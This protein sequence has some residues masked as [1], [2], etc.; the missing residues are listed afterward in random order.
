VVPVRVREQD[1]AQRR[2][3]VAS[4]LQSIGRALHGLV[5][6]DRAEERGHVR[7]LRV[8]LPTKAGI[9]QQVAARVSDQHRGRREVAW[10]EEGPATIREGRRAMDD[11]GGQTKHGHARGRAT[12]RKGEREW[13]WPRERRGETGR[14]GQAQS[15]QRQHRQQRPGPG[16]RG[17]VCAM[18]R[19]R[20]PAQPYLRVEV[21]AAARERRD[22]TK[23]G[24]PPWMD[25]SD[26]W[27]SRRSNS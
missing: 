11:A 19:M 5:A 2:T 1:T 25:S 20:N 23:K 27:R 8:D 6:R 17:S 10:V 16:H 3:V 12:R 15:S 14:Q 9:D 22:E 18:A 21:R 7:K 24:T 4:T 13:R 26:C